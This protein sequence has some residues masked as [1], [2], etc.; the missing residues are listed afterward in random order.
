MERTRVGGA[1][2]IIGA[3]LGA[4]PAQAQTTIGADL[5]LFSSYVWRGIT[6]TNK[7]VIQ[8]DLYLTIPVSSASITVGGW[9]NIEPGSYDGTTDISENGIDGAGL[10]E[11]DWWGEVGFPVGPKTTLTA[12]VTGYVFPNDNG[13]TSDANTIELYGKAAFDVLLSPKLAVWYDVDKIKGAYFE[14]SISHS[15]P[16]SEKISVTLGA[17]AGLNA[18]QG[19]PDDPLSDQSFNFADNGFTHLDLSAGVPFSAGPLSISPALHVV[20]TGDDATKFTKIDAATGFPN[21]KDVK[22]W[23][24]VTIGWSK[25]LGE[26]PAEP[27]E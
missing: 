27:A 20:I 19:I 14:G 8:P 4:V 5:G 11:F 2:L 9:A 3:L 15:I 22:L 13:F 21:S 10:A 16:A 24:G 12:G 6:Y 18:G 17:A 26:A 25:A 7:P 23:G 1:F